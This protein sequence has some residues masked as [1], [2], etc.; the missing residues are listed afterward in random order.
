MIADGQVEQVG[1]PDE[2]YDHPA[3][4]FVMGF[5]GPV[6]T[7]GGALVRPHDLELLAAPTARTRRGDRRA[8]RAARLRGT[9]R[10]DDRRGRDLGATDRAAASIVSG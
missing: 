4:D 1:T 10:H 9:R 7:L 3:N 5:L 2:L 8:R 6:T